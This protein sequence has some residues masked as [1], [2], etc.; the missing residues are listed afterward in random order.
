MEFYSIPGLL[1]PL[2]VPPAA[3]GFLVPSSLRGLNSLAHVNAREVGLNDKRNSIP[4]VCHT[5]IS[6]FRFSIAVDVHWEF[7]KNTEDGKCVLCSFVLEVSK[8]EASG[9]ALVRR[10]VPRDLL[11]TLAR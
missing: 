4:G 6:I 7:G 1:D 3:V 10:R 11:L 9:L 2:A 5:P 8:V